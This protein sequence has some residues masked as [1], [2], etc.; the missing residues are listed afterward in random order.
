MK[1]TLF[2]LATVLS[3][4]VLNAQSDKYQ[5]AMEPLVAAVDTT[6]NYDGLLA[7]ANSFQRI[8][9]AEKTQWL[10]Y[11]YAAFCNVAAGYTIMVKDPSP[12]ALDPFAD[13]GEKLLNQA[14][15]LSKDNS[16]IWIVRTQIATMRL[17]ADPMNRYMTYG[18]LATEGLAT[19]KKLN[20][21]NPRV[22]LLE[23]QSKYYTPEQFGGSKEEAAKLFAVS[24][25][26]FGTF[27]PESPLAPRWG[28]KQLDY[29]LSMK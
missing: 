9:D 16:E 25:E 11:Y 27:K 4:V 7:L 26:K 6:W 19:A 15:A 17:S 13:K 3:S 23:G 20:P 1:K 18:P 8:A 2:I 21:E 5:K 12:A 14:E 22:Y 28:G 29:F 24:K 10:P